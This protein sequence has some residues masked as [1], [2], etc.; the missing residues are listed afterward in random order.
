M[1]QTTVNY[2]LK[3]WLTEGQIADSSLR[4]IDGAL[5][6]AI[7]H[8]GVL[9]FGRIAVLD[10]TGNIVSPLSGA[11]STGQI[12]VLPVFVEK[13]GIT[14]T[15]AFSNSNDVGYPA[16]YEAVEYLTK[17]DIVMYSEEAVVMGDAVHYR[18][19]AGTSPNDVVGR[20][21]KSVDG[22]NTAQ[23]STA[24]FAET[25]SGAGLVA[26]RINATIGL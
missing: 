13:F 25:T 12:L 8:N 19:T 26:V 6:N 4:Q 21:R 7:N 11:P 10:T 5:H 20:V 9:P 16:D 2:G 24:V 3:K 22:A 17:G 15:Q 1:P 18:H 23:I 14:L